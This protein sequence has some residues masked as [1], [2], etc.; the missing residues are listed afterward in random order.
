[1]LQTGVHP[2][3]AGVVLGLMTP[4]VP[5]R[6]RE[7]PLD[8]A[9]RALGELNDLK[10]GSPEELAGPLK[11]LQRA[12][13]EVLP[14][15][16]RVQMAL[17]PWVAFGVMPLFALA[18]AG[19]TIDGVDLSLGS[20]QTVTLGV[21]LALVLGKPLGVIA[22]SWLA[23]RMGWCRLPPGVNWA[24]VFLVGLLAGIGFTMSIFIATLAFDDA[25][26]LNAANLGVLL[27]SLVAALLGLS[28]GFLQAV[29]GR[30]NATQA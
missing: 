14:P 18:N 6:L 9:S 11:H 12:Q 4:V 27:A 8:M 21:V 17:H 19:V 25:N 10:A 29:R 23:V 24:S 26:L 5:G 13:R 7:Q 30:R 15:V 16:I 20:A 2:T 22:A 3:L 28:W 1:M